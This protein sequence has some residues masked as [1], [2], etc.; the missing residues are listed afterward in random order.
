VTV[1]VSTCDNETVPQV[2]DAGLANNML[3]LTGCATIPRPDFT[4]ESDLFIDVAALS[5]SPEA[6]TSV[7][8]S[9][10]TPIGDTVAVLASDLVPD[11]E[12][13]CTAVEGQLDPAS[14]GLSQRFTELVDDPTEMVASLAEELE[15]VDAVVICALTPT[16]GDFAAA[17][18][19]SGFDQPVFVP[20]FGD[21]QPW[22]NDMDDVMIVAP[23]SRY[24]DD[25]VD[26]VNNLTNIVE[27]AESTDIVAADTLTILVGAVRRT[28]SSSPARLAD[29]LREGPVDGLGG[30]LSLDQGGQVERTYRLIEVIDGT[31]EFSNLIELQ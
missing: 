19:D 16:I 4:T 21:D 1:L 7:L 12:D 26:D 14:I 24:G 20:W 25:P 31:P 5:T 10:L 23:S 2:V 27:N 22:P 6:I 8:E 9:S 17:L 13:E 15:A 11:V 3:V 30:E 18:R 29:V 28:G